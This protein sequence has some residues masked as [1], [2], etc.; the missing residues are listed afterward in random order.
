MSAVTTNDLTQVARH[1]SCVYGGQEEDGELAWGRI[2]SNTE[3]RV[4]RFAQ[5]KSM[6]LSLA[7]W[8]R[9]NRIKTKVWVWFLVSL[10]ST[11]ISCALPVNS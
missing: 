4:P 1:F 10:G 5:K 11:N 7:K 8:R 6:G 2:H 3:M 9:R